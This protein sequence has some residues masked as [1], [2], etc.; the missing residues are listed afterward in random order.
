[1]LIFFATKI[2]HKVKNRT[3]C[4]QIFNFCKIQRNSAEISKFCGKGKILRLS[5]KFHSPW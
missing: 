4:R 2:Y 5:S 3:N 1:M